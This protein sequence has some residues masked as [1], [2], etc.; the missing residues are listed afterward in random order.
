MKNTKKIK[1]LKYLLSGLLLF[2]A[3]GIAIGIC[4]K[5]FDD[6]KQVSYSEWENISPSSEI[7]RPIPTP[8]HLIPN[9]SDLT[10]SSEITN[11]NVSNVMFANE[12]IKHGTDHYLWN[13]LNT[14][15]VLSDNTDLAHYGFNNVPKNCIEQN[16]SQFTLNYETYL[17]KKIDNE[18]ERLCKLSA[19]IALYINGDIHNVMYSNFTTEK[20]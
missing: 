16:G 20:A 17:Y 2:G 9:W 13:Y 1:L 4:V 11:L 18:Y 10:P 7:V 14:L 19:S 12:F 8:T 15:Y 6:N 5:S 3:F